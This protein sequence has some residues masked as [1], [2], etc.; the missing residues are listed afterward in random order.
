[1]KKLVFILVT[2]SCTASYAAQREAR[3]ELTDA[4]RQRF[5]Y[6]FYEA[7][8]CYEA[9]EY[10]RALALYLFAEQI[11]PDDAAVHNALGM[12]YHG[13]QESERSLAHFQKAYEGDPLVYWETYA[14]VLFNNQAYDKA[15]EVL[16]GV[17]RQLPENTDA[18]ESLTNVYIRQ[19]KYKKALQLQNRLV[20][21]EGV[22]AYNTMARYRILL[23]MKKP[24]KAIDIIKAF[25]KEE[26]EDYRM[27]TFLGDIYF[28]IGET[29]KALEVYLAEQERHPDNPYN[30]LSLGKLYEQTHHDFQAA[31]A[32]VNAI[33]CEELSISEKMRTIRTHAE[34]IQKVE[35]LLEETLQTLIA[36][37]PLEAEIYWTLGTTYLYHQEYDKAREMAQAMIALNPKNK[38][39]W[40]MQLETLQQDSTATDSLYAPIIRSAYEHFPAE[41]K[42]CYYMGTVLLMEDKMDSAIIVSQA[43]LQ[44]SESKE[45]LAYQQAI[46]TR[47]GDIYSSKEM[48]DSAYFYYEEVLRYD[49]EN[50][51]TLN[52]YAYLLATHGGDL[53]KAEKMSQITIKKEPDNVIYLDTYAWILHLQGVESLAKFYIQKALDNIGDPTG[54]E[55]ILEH[56]NVI[57]APL[58][59]PLK[60]G[61]QQHQ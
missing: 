18:A 49:P 52:N 35:G 61:N 12:L 6:Y 31:E 27:Q 43:G 51:Y 5:L 13:L 7:A 56:Y 60:E 19:E 40:D 48:L 2:L 47:L 53:R 45:R 25:L 55:E 8:R 46:R 17:L 32:T 1:M 20:Q 44:P 41:P 26:P 4:E 37:Y 11:N 58:P 39:A 36:E 21:L 15:A 59:S 22:N 24:E 28:S 30:Y 23:L 34:R 9:A 16:E 38:Q 14:G 54:K 50:I 57:V 33:L 29:N 3:T 42:W 10:D